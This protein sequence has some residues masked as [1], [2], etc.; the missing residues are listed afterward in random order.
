[1]LNKKMEEVKIG[2]VKINDGFWK[3]YVELVRDEVI[4]YQWEALND[5][6]EGAEPSYCINNFRIAAG[7]IKGEVKG[8]IFQDS[9]IYKWI[10]AVSYKLAAF[11]DA[12]IEKTVD[13]VIDLIGRAQQP[14]GYLNTYFT[15]MEPENRWTN[16]R[17]RH[18]LYCAG[19]LI[20][21]A[22]AH[23]EA[24]GKKSLLNIACKFADYI[25]TVF[26]KEEGKKHGY[27]GHQVIEMALLR[28][29]RATNNEKYLML[30]KYFIDERGKEPNYYVLEA[31]EREK[32]NGK[33]CL[34]KEPYYP[35]YKNGFE[36]NQ[37]H[38]P[39]RDQKKA[40]GHAVRAMYM[41][42]AMADLAVETGDESLKE[43]CETL[44]KDVT[45]CQM[46]ITGGVG[47]DEFGEAFSFD[48]DM[49][50]DR[51]YTETCASVGM[52]FWANKMFQL[53]PDSK[54]ADIMERVLY[55]GAISGMSLDGKKFFYV[56]PLEVWPEACRGRHDTMHVAPERQKWF[57]CA[58]CPPN[59]ARLIASIGKY[60]Y[61]KCGDKIYTHLYIS[62]SSK[63][64]INGRTI[65][66]TQ[67]G[68]YPWDETM[69][70]KIGDSSPDSKNGDSS[71]RAANGDSSSQFTLAFRIPD[72]C[73]GAQIKV[74]GQAV[75]LEAVTN[76][77]YAEIRRA[78]NDKDEIEV[79]LPMP[80]EKIQAN[81]NVR[82]NAGKIAIQRGPVVYCIEEADNG[83][84]L[85]DI[86]LK[87]SVPLT[88]YYDEKLLGGVTVITGEGTRS[89]MSSWEGKLYRPLEY[90]TVPV[91]VKA[92]PYYAWANRTLGEMIL[93]LRE[94][95]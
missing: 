29:Y 67:Q 72:W 4:P 2:D 85:Q 50:N 52:V 49:P 57:A 24:T 84:D 63:F 19:H 94:E 78:W 26:G 37:S 40:V 25:D 91:K 31:Q 59:I 90:D 81:P 32:K 64:N 17:D 71:F 7:E 51:A 28:L 42:T 77:G 61:T 3:R 43:A 68:N 39:V 16:E 69:T 93:W 95:E 8:R 34:E 48:Y 23:F 53:D 66:L 92:I 9:D 27:P 89:N 60:I 21:A 15:V 22:V 10:E 30:C 46:Y 13:D 20:E 86:R 79:Y 18:E 65:E 70:M 14:D 47:S 54:Y 73:K 58:C 75:D 82:N 80:V 36:Y 87:S 83:P 33:G 1:M 55:N 6:V 12:E 74:N 62:S 11:P 38:L 88:S 45:E 5:R 44:W 76:K 56:N 41:Y 35:L